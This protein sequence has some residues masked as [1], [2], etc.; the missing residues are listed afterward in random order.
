[1]RYGTVSQPAQRFLWS[2]GA[3]A[4]TSLGMPAKPTASKRHN[5][6]DNPM[7]FLRQIQDKLTRPATLQSNHDTSRGAAKLNKEG[8]GL[9]LFS[10]AIYRNPRKAAPLELAHAEAKAQTSASSSTNHK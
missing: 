2:L 9:S 10:F 5:M 3:S 8:I 1:M 6:R 4:W 7:A